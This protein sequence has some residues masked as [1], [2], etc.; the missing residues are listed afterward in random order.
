[1]A[2]VITVTLN[3]A[4][5]KTIHVPHLEFNKVLRTSKVN[6]DAGGKGF[7]ISRAL[8][9][10]GVQSTVAGFLGGFSG[11][12]IRT[13]LEKMGFDLLITTIS[14]E[15][16]TNT[17]ILGTNDCSQIKVNEPGPEIHVDEFNALCV[18]ITDMVQ[19]GDYLVLSGSL[20]P[21]L[22]DTTYQ[23]M[24][25]IANQK[26]A[27]TILDSSG[28][29]MRYGLQA[30]PWLVKPNREE[31]SELVGFNLVD[32][33]DYLNAVNTMLETGINWISL[34][35]GGDGLLLASRETRVRVFP[36]PISVRNTVGA[37]DAL[38]AGLIYGFINNLPPLETA[39]WG[40]AAG[41]AAASIS[42]V[43]FGSMLEVLIISRGLNPYLIE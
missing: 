5:D 3:P 28:D 14:G 8:L 12:K 32:E 41:M 21:G 31:A 39:R 13:T 43:Q 10:L 37:G 6:W 4:L 30:K 29:A 20:P 24:I 33:E 26:G 19:P 9:A 42:N 1:M 22:A 17:V 7:N 11:E 35:L 36:T 27:R 15:T 38:L 25:A 18:Q 2:R 16:R 34:S 23:K 40:V